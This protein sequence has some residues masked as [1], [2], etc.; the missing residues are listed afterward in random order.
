MK[1]PFIAVTVIFIAIAAAAAGVYFGYIAK[2][3]A[4]ESVLPAGPVFFVKFLDADRQFGEFR[5]S[6]LYK[7]VESIDIGMLLE[8]S[9]MKK[10][11]AEAIGMKKADI[12]GFIDGLP[13]GTYFGKEASVALYPSG[14][15]FAAKIRPGAKFIDLLAKAFNKPGKIYEAKEEGCNGRKISVVRIGDKT[16]VAY[17]RIKDVLIAGTDKAAVLSCYDVAGKK[18]PALAQDKDF[19][20]A[21][22]ELAKGAETVAF[23]DIGKMIEGA[24]KAV[25]AIPVPSGDGIAADILKAFKENAGGYFDEYSGFGAIVY[26]KYPG[27]IK[28]RVISRSIDK[29]K[30]TPFLKDFYSVAPRGNVTVKF[31]PA[32]TIWYGWDTIEWKAYWRYI[33]EAM[34][35]GPQERTEVIGFGGIVSDFEKWA[36]IS[37]ENDLI[38]ALGDEACLCFTDVSYEGLIPAPKFV[39]IIK[40]RNKQVIDQLIGKF[41][42]DGHDDGMDLKSETYSN[43][44]IKYLDLPFG[45]AFQPAYCYVGDYLLL[46]MGRMPVKNSIDSYFGA[47]K[48]LLD[49]EDFRA[50]NNGPEGAA[51]Q[52]S[53][54]D[55][56]ALL[57]E[58][59]NFSVGA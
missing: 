51:N 38:P 58:T 12:T 59:R 5:S 46:S 20:A 8:K 32:D 56:D 22:P 40:V 37:V 4:I 48:S 11:Q 39:Y 52:V 44:E 1:K 18:L 31:A 42:Q 43:V 55:A 26:A 15:I 21:M 10:E 47:A 29:P 28:K 13:F 41:V 34:K 25:A 30:M 17:I 23:G 14:V 50:V 45:L 35:N 2:P 7:N 19:A 49:N 54:V 36:G 16:S 57:R 6:K 53:F 9:G 33:R 24:K 3:Q 27:E